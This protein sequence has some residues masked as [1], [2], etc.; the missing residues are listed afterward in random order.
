MGIDVARERHGF[1]YND[2]AAVAGQ[3]ARIRS[4]VLLYRDHP[5][6]LMWAIG[7]EL[8]L[9]AN[10]PRVW[11]AVNQIAEMIH[12]LDPNHPVMTTLAGLDAPLVSELKSRAPALDLIGIQLYGDIE[13]LPG[14]LAG[15][16][17]TGPYVVTEW[18]PTGHW[19]TTLTSWGAPIEDDSTRKAEVVHDRYQRFIAADQRQSLGS[20]VFL[21]GQKQERTPTWY[22]MFLASGE[23][24][25]VVDAM[26][27]LWTGRWPANLSPAISPIR[28]DGRLAGDSIELPP[29]E[30]RE[31]DVQASDADSG[32][33]SYRW[34]LLAESSATSSGGDREDVP[35]AM[36]L[37]TRVAAM[38]TL[39]FRTPHKPGSYR[40][41][42]TVSDGS[43]NAAHANIPFRVV[44]KR[45]P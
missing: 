31:A 10:N 22:G 18:G 36:T 20:Y 5:A 30:W 43:G 16:G 24:T 7:N 17:W 38:G 29:G 12:Q 35:Q 28:L 6:L 27:H 32:P 19:E 39:R 33:P 34:Q 23:A 37:P 14:K 1:D 3:L 40:L 11:D 25:A 21:W 44:P 45:N 15:S 2:E 26:Q 42:V 41:F 8:N 9:G 4:E 13:K